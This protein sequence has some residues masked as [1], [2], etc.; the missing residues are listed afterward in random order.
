MFKLFV[1]IA[2]NLIL[3]EQGFILIKVNVTLESDKLLHCSLQATLHV[4]GFCGSNYFLVETKPNSG[5]ASSKRAGTGS[6]RNK[7]LTASLMHTSHICI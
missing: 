1:I 7:N 6:R 4:C 2:L 3:F 5:V